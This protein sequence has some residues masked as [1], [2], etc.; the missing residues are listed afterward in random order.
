MFIAT[1][2]DVTQNYNIHIR[3]DVLRAFM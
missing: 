2:S 3:S 1:K